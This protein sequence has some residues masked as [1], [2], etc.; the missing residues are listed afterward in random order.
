MVNAFRELGDCLE[1][2]QLSCTS[3]GGSAGSNFS[4]SCQHRTLS[5]G[6]EEAASHCRLH[7][8]DDGIDSLWICWSF[9]NFLWRNAYSDPLLRWDLDVL[10]CFKRFFIYSCYN[11]FNKWFVP[12][13]LLWGV[14]FIMHSVLSLTPFLFY[15]LLIVHLASYQ[16]LPWPDLISWRF[17]CVF[18][19]S[20]FFVFLPF[21][22]MIST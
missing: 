5:A 8:F 19:L 15:I 20:S 10:L 1:S 11:C 14:I 9:Y 7:F 17:T 3:C 12:V 18:F 21:T 4:T 16:G 22:C 6:V 2:G 13:S